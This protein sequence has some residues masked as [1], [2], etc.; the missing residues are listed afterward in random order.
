MAELHAAL[1]RQFPKYKTQIEVL[2]A[3]DPDF[4]DLASEYQRLREEIHALEA[5]GDV[6]PDYTNL[7]NRRDALQDELVVKM[8]EARGG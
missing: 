5:S 3:S 6:G 2:I 4:E 8:Q 7:C 1:I